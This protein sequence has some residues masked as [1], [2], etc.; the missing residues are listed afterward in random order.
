MTLAHLR[1]SFLAVSVLCASIAFGQGRFT[2][3]GRMK[4]DGGSLEGARAVVYKN[5]V[6]E[7]TITTGL[8][9]FSLTLD[10]DASY[11]VSFEREGYVAKKISFDTHVPADAVS[12]GF[13]PFDFAVAL[14]KQYDD[15]NIVVFN[16]PVGMIRY[17]SAAGDFDYDTDYTK[18]IQ[19]QLQE[20]V[21][22]VERKQKEEAQAA[23]E[24]EKRKSEEA[25]EQTR[26]QAESEKKAQA[27]QRA[28][29]EAEKKAAADQAAQ[30]RAQAEAE[31]AE[32]ARL[33]TARKEEE[34]RK[35]AEA[36]VREE[37]KPKPPPAVRQEKPKPLPMRP[38]PERNTL[39]SK[40]VEGE[41][42]RRTA[43]PVMAEEASPVEKARANAEEEE[44][45][46]IIVEEPVT[47]R[48]EDLV[49][50]S[51]KVTTVVKLETEGVVTEYR[52]VFH[53]WGGTFYFKNG[54]TCTQMQY[55]E[56]TRQE[57][58]AGATPRS[59]LD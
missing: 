55:E 57:Q 58:L 43:A 30:A 56:E 31:R 38:A 35:A 36:A 34:K 54:N 33:E 11:V 16:Q 40:P 14:F 24:Q 29:A 27:D 44:R 39:A 3:N 47:N 25:R 12:N 53:K 18:S 21:E 28:Q 49:V 17:D 4:V 37:P 5:G 48:T 45:P 13:T 10:L 59:K 20:V 8:S 22:Q 9:K 26:A 51:G 50:E 7:R 23:V 15:I 19:S 2:V 46:E 42:G 32:K 6:K 1:S 52:R 41:D